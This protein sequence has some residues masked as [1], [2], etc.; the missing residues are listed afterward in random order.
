MRCRFAVNGEVGPPDK[1]EFAGLF[2]KPCAIEL[3]TIYRHLF[4]GAGL[5]PPV[6][7]AEFG[8]K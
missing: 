3:W 5:D 6:K 2:G 1:L 8:I 4:V 7:P